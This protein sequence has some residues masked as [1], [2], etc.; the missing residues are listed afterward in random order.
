MPSGIDLGRN[1]MGSSEDMACDMR[2]IPSKI[3]KSL[4]LVALA[5][6]SHCKKHAKPQQ[7]LIRT[8]RR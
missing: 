3:R 1:P 4:M 6:S 5:A 7:K 8:R 2:S